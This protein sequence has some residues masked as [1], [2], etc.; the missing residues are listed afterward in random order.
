MKKE[1]H[2]G[3]LTREKRASKKSPIF[4]KRAL[5]MWKETYKK[6]SYMCENRPAY[7]ERVPRRLH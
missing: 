7:V 2:D 3:A 1:P 5:Y 6:E 4:V